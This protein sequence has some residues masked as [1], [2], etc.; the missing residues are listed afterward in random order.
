MFIEDINHA[1]MWYFDAKDYKIVFFKS[2][3]IFTIYLD[4]I[5]TNVQL[6]CIFHTPYFFIAWCQNILKILL[7][8]FIDWYYT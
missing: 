4:I 5:S 7:W 2:K 3:V 8:Y 6:V 1:R